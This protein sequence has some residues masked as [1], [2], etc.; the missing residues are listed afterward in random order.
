MQHRICGLAI[1]AAFAPAAV[2][3]E[4]QERNLDEISVTATREARATKDVPASIAVVGKNK[5]G[6][7]KMM[8][9]KE[10]L[11]DIPGVLIDSKNGG[12]DA[13]LVVRGAGL[14]AA[15][16]IREVMVLRDGVP[17]TDPDGL[18]KL[19][20][21]DTQDIERIEVTKGP[22]NLYSPGS[23]GGAIQ[24]ISKSVFDDNANSGRIG[25][26]EF[27]NQN[28][29]LRYGGMVSDNQA[30]AFTGS[31]RAQDN[32]WRKWNNFDTK[33]VGLKHGLVVGNNATLESEVSYSEANA[34][35]PGS[36]S[37][38][39]F[40]TFKQTGRQTDTQD[41]WKNSG[42]Y[43]KIWFLNSK[44]EQEVGDWMFKPRVYY[45][46]WT[47]YHPVTGI[48]NDTRDW[49]QTYGADLEVQNR[50]RLGNVKGTLVFGLTL[51]QTSNDDSRQ[52]QYRDVTMG[53]GRITAT[54]SDTEGALANIQS[55]TDR[56]AG[57]FIQESLQPTERLLI[58]IGAR[59]DRAS[60]DVN[61]QTYSCYD[62]ASGK[63]IAP[64]G[65]TCLAQQAAD[66]SFR[67]FSPKLGATFR[68]SNEINLYG[69]V[70]QAD[71]V[72]QTS[73]IQQNPNLN[74]PRHHMAEIGLKGRAKEWSFDIAYYAGTVNDEVVQVRNST[75]TVYQNA[76]KVDKKGLE[77][78][79]AHKLTERW[80]TGLSYSHADYKYASFTEVG[81]YPVK[82]YDRSGKQLPWIPREQ[83][84]LFLNY[85]DPSGLR[86][87]LQTSTWGSYYLD[88]ANSATYEGYRFVTNLMVGYERGPHTVALNAEN[89]TDKHYAMEVK[90]DLN[91]TVS[92]YA[93]VPRNVML[94]YRYGFR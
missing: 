39:Q 15:Y 94:T 86:A 58:D 50:H 74:A 47:H 54:L 16:G 19:D 1:A 49:T 83:Y 17:I 35:L 75:Q 10:G 51:R 46:A 28:L 18:T 78:T 29:H 20:F 56:L 55:Y 40:E 69:N 25:L 81:G 4:D 30:L 7:A 44:Y 26:G 89:I 65:T 52:Y 31:Y 43:S 76:G 64:N 84:S 79:G 45:N 21:I 60:F 91:G 67:L 41:A 14:N 53:A 77:L 5:L 32:D 48:I 37:A 61:T 11:S 66:K 70:A 23:A 13:R 33:Q 93:A 92:Y 42:R 71:Q 73:Y 24:I 3:A 6:D 2:L 63:Y 22:G 68:L 80:E 62:Y 82:Q 38:A 88:N 12:Y 59:L 85:R 87:R 34:Q 57:V 72:L 36:M 8:N 27:K 9:I 90:K